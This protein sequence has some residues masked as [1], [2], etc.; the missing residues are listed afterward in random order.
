MVVL[1]VAPRA[2]RVQF[3]KEFDPVCL[4]GTLKSQQSRLLDLKNK[5]RITQSQWNLN[6]KAH[7]NPKKIN[8]PSTNNRNINI[9]T[10]VYLARKQ[11]WLKIHQINTNLYSVPRIIV[12]KIQKNLSTRNHS[13]YSSI[14]GPT[15]GNFKFLTFVAHLADF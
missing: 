4:R 2:V 12:L 6:Q 10:L 14:T 15:L 1:R 7:Q 8:S 5:K 9:C 13:V 3:D 11:V